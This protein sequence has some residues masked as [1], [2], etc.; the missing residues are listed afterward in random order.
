MLRRLVLCI[1][2]PV[3]GLPIV[4]QPAAHADSGPTPLVSQIAHEPISVSASEF[5]RHLFVAADAAR[6]SDPSNTADLLAERVLQHMYA[7]D[8]Q[9][10]PAAAAEAM[11]GLRQAAESV[12]GPA[13]DSRITRTMVLFQQAAAADRGPVAAT[14]QRA[15]TEVVALTA[16]QITSVAADTH[17][18]N[19]LGATGDTESRLLASSTFTPTAV[20]LDSATLADGNTS[21]AR[22]RHGVGDR[23]RCLDLRHQCALC[24]GRPEAEGQR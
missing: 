13:F 17:A 8:V 7:L 12:T 9:T 2:I 24:S 21:F 22:P 14:L 1:T 15:T 20:L 23:H 5:R 3:I 19:A 11:Q 4:T 18:E 10:D 16:Q 6:L